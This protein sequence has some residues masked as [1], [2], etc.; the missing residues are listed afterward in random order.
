MVVNDSFGIACRTRRVQD[1]CKVVGADRELRPFG[2]LADV[3]FG[4][5]DDV[6]VIMHAPAFNPT[7]AHASVNATDVAPSTSLSVTVTLIPLGA[8]TYPAPSPRS[9]PSWG[10]A[11]SPGR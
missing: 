5:V 2:G 8:L 9:S 4:C 3:E 1:A 6:N 7:V 11:R 10:R